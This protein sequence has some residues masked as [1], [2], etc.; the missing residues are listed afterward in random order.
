MFEDANGVI[1]RR[2]SKD[3][4]CNDPTKRDKKTNNYLQNTTQ[5]TKDWRARIP[6]K[7]GGELMCSGE[8]AV[9]ASLM[10]PVVILSK[11]SIPSLKKYLWSIRWS[12]I[13][14]PYVE[15]IMMLLGAC[16]LFYVSLWFGL[17]LVYRHFQ[18]YFSYIMTVSAI[19]GGNRST[20]RKPLTCRKSLTIFIT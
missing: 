14:E 16:A 20:R 17:V 4:Q 18:Q 19:D 12:K 5:K 6:L 8:E 3:R 2:K 15:E 10:T 11:S 9:P 7:S 13:V 1:R